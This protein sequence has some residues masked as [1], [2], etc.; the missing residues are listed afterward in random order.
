MSEIAN[1]RLRRL[2]TKDQCGVLVPHLLD[3]LS[4]QQSSYLLRIRRHIEKVGSSHLRPARGFRA[5]QPIGRTTNGAQ[6]RF[7]GGCRD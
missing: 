6:L 5:S 7:L 2:T 4:K 1:E 3:H